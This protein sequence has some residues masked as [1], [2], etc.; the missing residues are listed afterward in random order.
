MGNDAI[1]PVFNYSVAN[2]FD[3]NY[4]K[5]LNYIASQGFKKALFQTLRNQLTLAW[6]PTHIKPTL[7]DTFLI[8]RAGRHDIVRYTFLN[9]SKANILFIGER[10]YIYDDGIDKK[11][12][13]PP[14]TTGHGENGYLYISLDPY[15]L[16]SLSA[17]KDYREVTRETIAKRILAKHKAKAEFVPLIEMEAHKRLNI[18][19]LGE[20]KADGKL[21]HVSS[22]TEKA[23]WEWQQ[24]EGVLP[25]PNLKYA[26]NNQIPETL[27][28]INTNEDTLQVNISD[29]LEL[30]DWIYNALKRREPILVH[31]PHGMSLSPSIVLAIEIARYIL[32]VIPQTQ[33]AIN[34]EAN[35]LFIPAFAEE[36]IRLLNVVRQSRSPDAI[37]TIQDLERAIA[38]GLIFATQIFY[39]KALINISDLMIERKID[40]ES[41]QCAYIQEALAITQKTALGLSAQV[42]DMTEY[43][44]SVEDENNFPP[45]ITKGL[46]NANWISDDIAIALTRLLEIMK[47][48]NQMLLT[49]FNHV[50]TRVTQED[51]QL[52]LQ[53][54]AIQYDK[55]SC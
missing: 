26:F 30:A 45:Y 54:D 17:T 25:N 50:N 52:I 15:Q 6:Q 13:L 19:A 4:M 21:A 47:L 28:Y 12:P 10:G 35:E 37:E 27:I 46:F 24:Q 2:L 48:R 9:G 31:C 42:A 49:F 3:N 5:D 8:R 55:F 29:T 7:L 41:R 22:Y 16:M 36:I 34:P 39:N 32:K 23:G 40:P 11:F 53:P 14:G 44:K 38:L 20:T 1:R 18:I 43:L 51:M 33:A